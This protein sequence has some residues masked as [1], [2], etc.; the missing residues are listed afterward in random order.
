LERLNRAVG[1]LQGLTE[2]VRHQPSL[3]FFGEPPVARRV[4]DGSGQ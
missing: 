1:N 2:E 3:L 4:P